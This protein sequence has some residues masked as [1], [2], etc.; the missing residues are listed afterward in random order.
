VSDEFGDTWPPEL[1]LR[2][3]AACRQFEERLA[4]G[5]HPRP[6]DYLAGFDGAER[7]AL[8]VEL[9]AVQIQWLARDETVAQSGTARHGASGVPAPVPPRYQ[10]EGVLGEGGMGVVYKARDTQLN[11]TV[12]LKMIRDASAGPSHLARF[13]A[14]AEAVAALPHQNVVQIFDTGEHAGNPYLVLEFVAGGTLADRLS[15]GPLAPPDAARLVET[16]ARALHS[17]HERNIVHR[18]LKPANVLFTAEGAPK[19]T[20]FGLVKRLDA[21]A[22]HTLAGDVMGTPSYMPPEQARGDAKDVGPTADVYALGAI[23]YHCLTGR[24]PFRAATV[25]EAIR[26]VLH[27][28]PARPRLL[29]A[30]VPDDLEAVCLKCLEKEQSHRY[31]TALALADDLRNY[32]CGRPTDRPTS[33]WRRL[34]ADLYAKNVALAE[35]E[36]AAGRP[37]NAG[38]YLDACPTELRGW[39]W[40]CLRGLRDR[41]LTL[42]EHTDVVYGVT[43]SHDGTRIASVSDDQTVRLWEVP[44]AKPEGF[45]ATGTLLHTFGGHTDQLYTPRFTPDGRSLVTASQAGV[46]KVWD[47]DTG[48]VRELVGHTDVVVGVALSHDGRFVASASDDTTVRLWEF[49]SGK[50]L[51]VF[52]GHTDMVNAVCF[53]PDGKLLASASY[54]QT[55]RVWDVG[56]GR[57]VHRLCKHTGFVW[58]V[59]FSPD[60]RLLASAGGD[61]VVRMWEVETGDERFALIGHSGVVWSV[62]FTPDGTRLAS[63]GWDKTVRLWDTASGQETVALRAH[64]DAVNAIAFSPDGTRLASAS[65][66]RTITVWVADSAQ[67]KQPV[68]ART[69]R[70]HT[71]AVLSVAFS[72]NGRLLASAGDDRTARVWD[73]ETGSVLFALAG[74]SAL[75]AAVGFAP[76]GK[77][78]ATASADKTVRLWETETGRETRILRGHTDRIYGLAFS[79]DGHRLATGGWDRTVRLWDTTTGE[80]VRVFRGHTNWVWSVAFSPDGTRLVSGSTDRTVR[81]WNLRTTDD[82]FVLR[83]H[84]LKVLGVAFSPDGRLVASAGGNGVAKM[85]DAH[86][87]AEIRTLVGHTDRVTAVAFDPTGAYLATTSEDQTV[88]TWE[89]RT[90]A[91]VH[92]YI[93]HA[94]TVSAVAFAPSGSRL[95]SGGGEGAVMVWDVSVQ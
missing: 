73:V 13:R 78:I 10:I 85:W 92:T 38:P 94:R 41:P 68:T 89:A 24:P 15:S 11:R 70:D 67:R 79:P 75:V 69:F 66:D 14:E 8:R 12:A 93:G 4:A 82:P 18:D 52:R 23:L 90:G 57:E 76:D 16:L 53:S 56:T 36:W 27:D 58:A 7:E 81:V 74:H 26:Q 60:G 1:A 54:D 62:A 55:V 42:R 95:A 20:D 91:A 32:L 39:E 31:P 17:A 80:T 43:F 61:A 33:A 64:A 30:E 9:L 87:G 44:S 77:T 47:L 49:D 29:R 88:R 22:G 34:E 86:T 50:E 21:T 83:G 25:A 71:G 84:E 5:E 51:R 48:A 37:Q 2:I 6:D 59:S 19:V 28:D 63:A 65:D 46:V 3:D 40:Y 72:P 35:R 45:A